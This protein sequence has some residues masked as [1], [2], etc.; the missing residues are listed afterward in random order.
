M[1][2]VQSAKISTRIAIDNVLITTDFSEASK[3]SLPYAAALAKQFGAKVFVTHVLNPEPLLSVPLDPMPPEDDRAWQDAEWNLVKFVRSGELDNTP[4]KTVLARGDFWAS[5]A[6][7]IGRHKIDLV[8]TGSRGRKGMSRLAL[9]SSAEKIYRR[10]SC[11]V[12]TIGPSVRPLK[13]GD[14]KPS[15]I[16]FPTDGS[17]I[18][19]KALPYALS[20]AEENEATLVILQLAPLV[21]AE[22]REA[23][24]ARTREAL[25]PLVPPDAEVWCKP[26]FVVRFEFPAEGILEFAKE[27]EVDLIVMGV[28]KSSDTGMPDHLPW[29]VA[30]RVVAEAP[31]PVLTVRG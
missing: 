30:S 9:G 31:C 16:L 10:A 27:R 7:L 25:R 20:L 17:E 23:E 14:W 18:S 29:P 28:R 6:G 24:E 22:L 8:V 13:G 15:Q 19:L 12:L 4:Y 21:F 11:P 1:S 5:I 2:T 26:E 3:A